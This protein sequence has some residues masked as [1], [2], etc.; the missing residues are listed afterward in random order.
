[1]YEVAMTTLKNE[2]TT[3]RAKCRKVV[4][5]IKEKLEIVGLLRDFNTLILG[6]YG[7][8]RSTVA[9]IKITKVNWKNLSAKDR[10]MEV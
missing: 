10:C 4:L 9:D 5:T 8:G 6:K 7:I 3:P 1:M 2:M